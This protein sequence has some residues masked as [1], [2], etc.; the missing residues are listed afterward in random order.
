MNEREKEILLKNIFPNKM[1]HNF[2][3]DAVYKVE[4][5]ILCVYE[6]IRKRL[7]SIHSLA[8]GEQRDMFNRMEAV[9]S[10]EIYEK[11]ED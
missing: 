1:N 3:W 5:S 9:I 11:M 2:E 6:E 8:P 4:G 7:G 10:K